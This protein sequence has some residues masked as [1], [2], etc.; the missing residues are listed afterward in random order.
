MDIV[1]L[2]PSNEDDSAKASIRS[3]CEGLL[4]DV[5]LEPGI[6]VRNVAECVAEAAR[7]SITVATSLL[8]ARHVWGNSEITESLTRSL[9][10]NRNDARVLRSQDRRAAHAP[11][12]RHN[13]VALNLEPNIKESRADCGICKR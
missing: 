12:Q 1:I 2:P 4:W 5:G 8:E 9:Q 11:R 7:T 13:D 3:I 10:N 6:A